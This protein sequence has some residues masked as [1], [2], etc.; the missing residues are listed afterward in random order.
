[1]W[2]IDGTVRYP[3][4]KGKDTAIRIIIMWETPPSLWGAVD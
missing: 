1:M 3:S 4:D 2:Q